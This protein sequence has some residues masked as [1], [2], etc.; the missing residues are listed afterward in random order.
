M[1]PCVASKPFAPLVRYNSGAAVVI[2]LPCGAPT[3]SNIAGLL[4]P[5]SFGCYKM[6][7]QCRYC[8]FGAGSSVR[9]GGVLL[10]FVLFYGPFCELLLQ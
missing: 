10:W 1:L 4:F 2:L 7:A 3:K 6:A 8:C 5:L 9:S